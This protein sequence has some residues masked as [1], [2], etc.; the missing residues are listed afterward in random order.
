[1][2]LAFEVRRAESS[3]VL[4]EKNSRGE[5][6]EDG[7]R[8]VLTDHGDELALLKVRAGGAGR[9]GRS[10]LRKTDRP[11]MLAVLRGICIGMFQ[12]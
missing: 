12:N 11:A 10:S 7:A 6:V 1:M 3:V 2:G 8:L 4:A 5:M 9:P